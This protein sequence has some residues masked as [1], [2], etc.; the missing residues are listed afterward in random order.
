MSRLILRSSIQEEAEQQNALEFFPAYDGAD[1]ESPTIQLRLNDPQDNGLPFQGP[2]GVGWT[3]I[4]EVMTFAHEG[5]RTNFFW[6][7]RDGDIAASNDSQPYA[8]AHLYPDAANNQGTDHSYEIS[9]NAGDFR[10]TLAASEHAAEHDVWLTQAFRHGGTGNVMRYWIKLPSTNNADIIER[11]ESDTYGA[12]LTVGEDD[13][14][15]QYGFNIGDAAWFGNYQHEPMNG[16]LGRM[17]IVAVALSEADIV[18]EA[19]DMSRLVTPAA[20]GAIWYGKTNW[21]SVDDLTCD[22][23]T[24]RSFHW[25]DSGNKATLVPV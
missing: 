4:F 24:G 2:G 8:G 15:P 23:G 6:A 17:K 5:Y 19:G 1:Q 21:R 22:Y 13:A 12:T 16:R 10:T 11:N 18:S 7:R 14:P 20:Q 25:V 3:Y 9:T